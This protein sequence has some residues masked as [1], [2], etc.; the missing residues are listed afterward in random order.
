MVNRQVLNRIQH[1]ARL[2]VSN[3]HDTI[4]LINGAYGF[5]QNCEG[6]LLALFSYIAFVAEF[7]S[8]D[9]FEEDI[10][11]VPEMALKV[12]GKAIEEY[13]AS[14]EGFQYCGFGEVY[15]FDL[16]KYGQLLRPPEILYPEPGDRA[17]YM[18]NELNTYEDCAKSILKLESPGNPRKV[19]GIIANQIT[20]ILSSKL[21]GEEIIDKDFFLNHYAYIYTEIER[22]IRADV[23][24]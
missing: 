16:T 5:P 10:E 17:T 6:A 12:I 2:I 14:D 20:K 22:F 3:S 23:C 1:N 24:Y 7:A 21:Y 4:T 9:L 8:I 19:L 13:P 18:L 15:G 11:V